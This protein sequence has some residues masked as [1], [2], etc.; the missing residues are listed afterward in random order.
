M[1]N[2]MLLLLLVVLLVVV[3]NRLRTGKGYIAQFTH[4]SLI[5]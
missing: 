1:Y 2:S 4:K 5:K 3:V